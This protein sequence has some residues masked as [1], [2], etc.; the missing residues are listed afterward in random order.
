VSLL[1]WWWAPVVGV[2]LAILILDGAFATSGPGNRLT[3]PGEVGSFIGTSVQ[4]VSLINAVV[5]GTVPPRRTT[6]PGH[7][8]V[9]SWRFLRPRVVQAG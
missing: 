9:G 2:A 5:A 4:M 8:A 3:E 6:G 1:S 7:E